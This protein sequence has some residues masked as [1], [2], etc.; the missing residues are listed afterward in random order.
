MWVQS[1]GLVGPL[2]EG[3]ATH[4]V[5]LSGECYGHK[6]LVGYSLQDH[7]ESDTTEVAQNAPSV[8]RL[9]LRILSQIHSLS[10]S[11]IQSSSFFIQVLFFPSELSKK[12]RYDFLSQKVTARFW[13]SNRVG[14]VPQQRI[15]SPIRS[16]VFSPPSLGPLLLPFFREPVTGKQNSP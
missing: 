11:Y 1:L 16:S 10:V 8:H 6:S 3:M 13:K 2:E 15:R 4:S 5:F 14:Q 12:M 9:Y 7:E